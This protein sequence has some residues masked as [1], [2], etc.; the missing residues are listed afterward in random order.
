MLKKLPYLFL[1]LLLLFTTCTKKQ[2]VKSV[3][4]KFPVLGSIVFK[5]QQQE[6]KPLL[7]GN[8]IFV[9]Y[10]KQ[11]TLT[12]FKLNKQFE[13]MPWKTIPIETPA[14]NAPYYQDFQVGVIGNEAFFEYHI[15]DSQRVHT[16]IIFINKEGKSV[17]VLH[18][19]KSVHLFSS[20]KGEMFFLNID[21]SKLSSPYKAHFF[22]TL[23]ESSQ[24]KPL[25]LKGSFYASKG[26]YKS[27]DLWEDS[28]FFISPFAPTK[29]VDPAKS[30]IDHSLMHLYQINKKTFK[31]AEVK[32]FSRQYQSFFSNAK[33]NYKNNEDHNVNKKKTI[34]QAQGDIFGTYYDNTTQRLYFSLGIRSLFKNKTSRRL[35]EK[36]LYLGFYDLHSNKLTLGEYTSNY[37]IPF[38]LGKLDNKMLIYHYDFNDKEN[39]RTLNFFE[40]LDD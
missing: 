29:L 37:A 39:I 10:A 31:I 35:L 18:F 5:D 16:Y 25:G 38:F 9:F 21:G 7:W 15:F 4:W 40:V 14:L 26:M 13:L 3:N 2:P 22:Y 6:Y 24:L 17:R 34:I 1:I 36:N 23:D 32:N 19:P 33:Q 27:A 20:V 12:V 28:V 30:D 8:N 11:K